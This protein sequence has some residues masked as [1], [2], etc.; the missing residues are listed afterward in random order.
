MAG[1]S[2]P[3]GRPPG[4]ARAKRAACAKSRRRRRC[5][6]RQAHDPPQEWRRTPT[7][8]PGPAVP[9]C[10]RPSSS[11]THRRLHARDPGP[12]YGRTSRRERRRSSSM[13]G[14]VTCASTPEE[15]RAPNLAPAT[16]NLDA[17]TS[18]R[19]ALTR[20]CCPAHDRSEPPATVRSA[21]KPEATR[22]AARGLGATTGG[23]RVLQDGE[24]RV[25]RR[26]HHEH[27]DHH[28]PTLDVILDDASVLLSRPL[29]LPP[30][31]PPIALS[32]CWI[33]SPLLACSSSS[34]TTSACRRP[35]SGPPALMPGLP[36][37]ISLASRGRAVQREA[38][39]GPSSKAQACC[40]F[41]GRRRGG[42][43]VFSKEDHPDE[44][45]QKRPPRRDHP[46]G[47]TARARGDVR[48]CPVALVPEQITRYGMRP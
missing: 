20:T 3:A 11:S 16:T 29:S 23:I 2:A 24:Q 17:R 32:P 47:R 1:R 12:A 46:S 9:R 28:L 13:T 5:S 26:A 7:P 48:R 35:A 39:D 21:R 18:L 14:P 36:C 15:P 10:R 44:T 6:R 45:T 22:S 42:G 30:Q 33:P 31:R 43:V 38:V 34:P 8:V 41:L 25:R 19:P 37:P 27:H 4:R 40:G